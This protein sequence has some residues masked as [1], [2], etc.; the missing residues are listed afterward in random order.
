MFCRTDPQVKVLR[1]I[2]PIKKEDVLLGQYTAKGDKPGYK[3]D[4][5]VPKESNCPTFAA[6][7]LYVNNPRWQGVPF[8]MKAGKGEGSLW[9]MLMTSSGRC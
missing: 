9:T 3:D 2:P 5:T 4:E 6:M 8:I 1:C 7:V